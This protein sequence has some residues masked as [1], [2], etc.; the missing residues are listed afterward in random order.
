MGRRYAERRIYRQTQAE[1]RQ[2]AER[3]IYEMGLEVKPGATE[4][5]IRAARSISNL[6][7][8]ERISILMATSPGGGTQVVAE[9]KLVFGFFD[10]GRNR[11]NVEA[12]FTS[13]AALVGPGEIAE[14]DS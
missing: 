9:S 6:S 10:W 14:L 4:W 2:A 11:Q 3:A 1:V 5:E 12:L 8:G 7:W 13:M